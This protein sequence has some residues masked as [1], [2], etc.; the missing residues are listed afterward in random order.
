MSN[1]FIDHALEY[2][3]Q[4]W[5]VIPLAPKNKICILNTWKPYQY[6]R[7]TEEEIRSW[8][9]INPEANIGIITGAISGI[10]ALDVDGQEGL[11][12]LKGKALP[13]TPVT[14]TGKGNHYIFKLPK[15]FEIKNSARKIGPGLDIRGE[16]G[17]IVA[18]PSIHAS[19]TKY[20]WLIQDYPAEAPEWL[21]NAIKEERPTESAAKSQDWIIQALRGIPKGQRDDTFTS[22]VGHWTNAGLSIEE[23]TEFL[24]MVNARCNP[25]ETEKDFEALVK[26][27]Y[28]R[29]SANKITTVPNGWTL[30]ASTLLMQ[31]PEPTKWLIEDLW[32]EES[33]GFIGGEPKTGKTWIGF[34]MAVSIVSNSPTLGHFKVHTPGPVLYVAEEGNEEQLRT[35]L[36]KITTAKSIQADALDDFHLAIQKNV[37]VDIKEWQTAIFDFCAKVKPRA[38]FFDPLVRIHSSGENQAEDMR[39]VLQFLRSIQVNFHCS[40]IVIHHQRK[41]SNDDTSRSGQKLRGTGDLYAWLDSAIYLKKK[42]GENTVIGV[43]IEH[44]NAGEVEP[45][46]LDQNITEDEA[47]IVYKEGSL[48]DLQIMELAKK[49]E[50]IILEMPDSEIKNSDLVGKIS[51]NE[52]LKYKALGL[53]QTFST[54]EKCPHIKR[55][56]RLGKMRDHTIWLKRN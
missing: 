5:S 27:I 33:C 37:M 18:P 36:H 46:T 23:Q 47:N 20:E 7:A 44:R 55:P 25:P 41:P 35:R 28:A 11:E 49:F 29:D 32:T 53:L 21:L 50:K 10:F 26:R 12:S 39:K 4:G 1:P 19:G 8:W 24:H 42:Q 22:L 30:S 54:V 51:G 38:V 2:L 48:A 56:D 16:G 9:A 34:D 14:K 13:P 43:E 15:G 52:K 45:F 17:Y 3:A 31:P 40:V 6:A